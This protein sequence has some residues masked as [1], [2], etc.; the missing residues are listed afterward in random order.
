M[1]LTL[2]LVG[3]EWPASCPNCLT[4][5]KGAPSFHVTEDSLDPRAGLYMVAMKVSLLCQESN[6]SHAAHNSVTIVTQP[7][8]RLLCVHTRAHVCLS[9]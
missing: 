1:L 6:S 2:A 7:Q 4:P 3:G 9:N 8:Q 5:G